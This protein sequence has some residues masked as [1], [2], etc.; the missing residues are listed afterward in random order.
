M[1]STRSEQESRDAELEELL[2]HVFSMRSVS[3]LHKE[4]IARCDFG[5][6]KPDLHGSCSKRGDRQRGRQAVNAEV[7]GRTTLE[8]VTR[9][10]LVK[11]LRRLGTC[12]NE[13]LS[14]CIS[15]SAIVT[16]HEL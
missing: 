8:A 14:L 16:C 15:V 6:W 9:Q 1:F 12:C 2:G 4:S 3:R 5:S 10:R 7:E 13:L 11:R